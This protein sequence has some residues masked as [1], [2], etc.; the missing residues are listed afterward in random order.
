[1]VICTHISSLFSTTTNQYSILWMSPSNCSPLLFLFGITGMFPSLALRNH[2]EEGGRG[3]GKHSSSHVTHVRY[4]QELAVQRWT[5][6]APSLFHSWNVYSEETSRKKRIDYKVEKGQFPIPALVI[7]NIFQCLNIGHT[8]FQKL[9]WPL[10]IMSTFSLYSP[11][12]SLNCHKQDSV[13]SFQ[14]EAT[15][16]KALCSW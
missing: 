5:M 9:H 8:Y 7:A 12:A 14:Q 3:F 15:E 1:M 11:N 6:H 10:L 4:C 2:Y 13:N 16:P